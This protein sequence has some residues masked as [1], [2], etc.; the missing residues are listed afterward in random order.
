[1]F[2]CNLIKSLFLEASLTNASDASLPHASQPF[3]YTHTFA[4]LMALSQAP[5]QARGASE[6]PDTQAMQASQ[7]DVS[8]ASAH[9]YSPP[10]QEHNQAIHA[11]QEDGAGASAELHQPGSV[12]Q[13]CTDRKKRD[14]AFSMVCHF[15]QVTQTLDSNTKSEV[16]LKFFGHPKMEV[17]VKNTRFPTQDISD[18]IVQNLKRSLNCVKGVHSK[19]ELAAKRAALHM[20]VNTS[21]DVPIS[22]SKLAKALDIQPRN[23]KK[24]RVD[25]HATDFKWAS[26]DRKR[27]TDC[28]SPSIVQ[29][30]S[31]YWESNSRVSPNKKDICRKRLGRKQ[32]DV[33]PT[34]FLELTEVHISNILHST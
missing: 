27:R 19:D 25:I 18:L 26:G 15:N 23:L 2:T 12:H 30:V 20:L 31:D 24:H 8:S 21:N 6:A 28:L 14:L 3:V 29:C 7:G 16:L 33:H 22:D 9:V 11:S 32:Y 17:V 1:M 10:S 13:G 34:H 5:S 4:L